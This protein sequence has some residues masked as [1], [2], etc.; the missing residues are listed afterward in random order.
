MTKKINEKLFFHVYIYGHVMKNEFLSFAYVHANVC[1]CSTWKDEKQKIK[2]T[3][4]PPPNLN[5]KLTIKK[6][7]ETGRLQIHISLGKVFFS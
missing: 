3:P 4:P 7:F 5:D 2:I 1:T 6:I